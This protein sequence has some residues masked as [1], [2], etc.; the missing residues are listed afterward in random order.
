MTTVRKTEPSFITTR[1]EV[2][3]KKSYPNYPASEWQLNYY[4]RGPGTGFNAAWGSE[5][6][7]DGDEFDIVVP[8]TKTDDMTVA[9]EYVWQAW[10]TEIADST[11]KI[12][13]G[14][15]RVKVILGFDPNS[16]TTVETRSPA[17]IMLDAIDAALLAFASGD[18]L[19]YEIST[20]AGSRRVKRS[21]KTT[22]TSERK[23]WATIVTNELARERA[24]NGKPLISSIKV[25]AH[26]E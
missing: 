23:Y 9:G 12:N 16:V 20:P 5:V 25:V 2:R 3:W 17:K 4:F 6:T 18:I 7:A 1:E 26:D 13:I 10:L 15:G 19:E 14:E 22:L 11:N 24:R 8:G 21:D